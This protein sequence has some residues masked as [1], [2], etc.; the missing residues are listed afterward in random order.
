[1]GTVSVAA[2]VSYSLKKVCSLAK[3]IL[4]LY[5]MVLFLLGEELT[6]TRVFHE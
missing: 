4:A 3:R 5:S 6:T 1:M 2:L